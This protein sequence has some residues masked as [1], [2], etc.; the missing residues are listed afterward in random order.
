MDDRSVSLGTT[1]CSDYHQYAT[2]ILES[3]LITGL[4]VGNF[5]MDAVAPFLIEQG[6]EKG[7]GFAKRLILEPEAVREVEQCIRRSVA[8]TLEPYNDDTDLQQHLHTVLTDF[9]R[10]G[11]LNFFFLSNTAEDPDEAAM[12]ELFVE[13]GGDPDTLP[14]SF[15]GLVKRT[16]VAFTEEIANAA[17]RNGSPLFNVVSVRRLEE[18]QNKLDEMHAVV[19]R[20]GEDVEKTREDLEDLKRGR[21]RSEKVPNAKALLDGPIRA[22]RLQGELNAADRLADRLQAAE[23][24]GRIAAKLSK[25]G[26]DFHARLI[27]HKRADALADGGEAEEAFRV[28]LNEA[29]DELQIGRLWISPAVARGIDTHRDKMPSF[30]QA[31]ADALEALEG[32]YEQPAV[33]IRILKRAFDVLIGLEDPG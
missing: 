20:V 31:T 23:A 26:Y 25:K 4:K 8:Q 2:G 9:L 3:Q 17:E 6:I 30:L 12:R 1:F 24:Y 29:A 16:A 27:R 14:E 18:I 15:D 7:V 32:W 11:G 33:S 21:R 5:P 19:T 28:W 22:L 13:L 10:R